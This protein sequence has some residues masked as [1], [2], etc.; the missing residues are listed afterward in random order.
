MSLRSKLL[1]IAAA[2]IVAGTAVPAIASAE[3]NV[4]AAVAAFKDLGLAPLTTM[5]SGRVVSNTVGAADNFG[6]RTYDQINQELANL[7]TAN[8]GLV[9]LKTA[10]RK[11]VE[12]R[13]IKYVEIANNVGAYDGRP[14][15]FM[16]GS[17]HGDEWAAGEHT[18][19]FIYDVINTSKTNPKVKALLDKVLMIVIPV[20]NVDGWTKS[21]RAN[22]RGVDMNR[23]YPF[24]WG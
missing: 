7:A 6:Y 8:P 12:G 11:S 3:P 18:M 5:P 1:T 10:P 13:D 15:Y 9:T 24:G 21:T 20:V 14:V 23:N 19:E 4:D 2:A 17:I 22:V 16:M